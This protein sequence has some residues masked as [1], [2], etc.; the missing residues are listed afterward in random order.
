MGN[1]SE[2]VALLERLKRELDG[3][4]EC[5][6]TRKEIDD[7]LVALKDAHY[8]ELSDAK[9]RSLASNALIL[10]GAVVRNLPEIKDFFGG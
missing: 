6:T 9:R 10:I 3:K 7:L 2:T 4:L 1:H 5:S 8:K